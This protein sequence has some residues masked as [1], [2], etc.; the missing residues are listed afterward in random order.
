MH[1]FSSQSWILVLEVQVPSFTDMTCFV[2][3]ETHETI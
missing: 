1:V 3:N 2:V